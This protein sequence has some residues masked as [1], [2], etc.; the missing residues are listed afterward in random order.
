MRA[1]LLNVP[2]TLWLTLTLTG[3]ILLIS[4]CTSQRVDLL[5]QEA[6]HVQSQTSQFFQIRNVQVLSDPVE[7]QTTAYGEVR[8]LGVYYNA[9]S[10]KRIL[11]E[12][13]FPDG[14][15]VRHMDKSLVSLH[16]IRGF[17][18]VYPRANFKVLLDQ[19]LSQQTILR[20]KFLT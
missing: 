12:A 1:S 7:N 3:L 18:S 20:L 8:R 5:D 6:V 19:T 4:A 10:G 13:I 15:V 9:F 14:S 2:K 17:R 16:R 11:V